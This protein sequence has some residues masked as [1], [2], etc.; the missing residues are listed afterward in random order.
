VNTVGTT[1]VAAKP[2]GER[3]AAEPTV[4]PRASRARDRHRDRVIQVGSQIARQ[5]DVPTRPEIDDAGGL[6][7]RTE[8]QREANAEHLREAERHVGIPGEVEIELQRIGDA[9]AP[10]RPEL[11]AAR[12]GEARVRVGRDGI[13]EQHFLREADR[14][15]RTA[16]R[17]V[18]R[19]EA[20]AFRVGELRHHFLVMQDRPGDQVREERHEQHV[21]QQAALADDARAAIEQIADLREREERDAERQDERIHRAVRDAEAGQE[22]EQRREILVMDQHREIR[23]DARA[24]DRALQARPA[25]GAQHALADR[26]V[27]R[28]RRGQQRDELRVPPAIEHE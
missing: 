5:R 1:I 8:I 6:V 15:Q 13:R 18:F 19:A 26:V 10:R 23:G 4:R 7:R 17:Q 25:G 3:A 20:V 21:A 27:E 12:R 9:R 16:H 14:E 2:P 24:G 11:Q 22:V 28:D